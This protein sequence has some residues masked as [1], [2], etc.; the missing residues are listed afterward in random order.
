MKTILGNWC[1]S[2]IVKKKNINNKTCGLIPG[3][4]HCQF[5]PG[6]QGDLTLQ[7]KVFCELLFTPAIRSPK[8]LAAWRYLDPNNTKSSFSQPQTAQWVWEGNHSPFPPHLPTL[9]RVSPVP[10]GEEGM[11]HPRWV[12]GLA[13]VYENLS[14]HDSRAGHFI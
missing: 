14:N 10:A 4:L 12:D 5:D 13:S 11:V 8:Y 7:S 2:S 6:L 3:L 1:C 9:F